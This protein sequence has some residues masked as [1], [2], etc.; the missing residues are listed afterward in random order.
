MPQFPPRNPEFRVAVERYVAAQRYLA[1]LGVVLNRI[2]PGLA[3][4]RLPYRED[5]GQQ[6][7]FFHGGVIGGIAEG[8]M[9]AAAAT[10]VAADAN[11]VG[12][13]YKVNLLS[14]GRGVALLA[15]GA[16][17]RPGRRLIVC[18]ADVVALDED[19]AET[20][21]AIAQG[22]MAVVE[23]PA[24][25]ADENGSKPAAEPPYPIRGRR[26]SEADRTMRKRASTNRSCLQE[27]VGFVLMSRRTSARHLAILSSHDRPSAPVA[28]RRAN[29][30]TA[31][32]AAPAALAGTARRE[33]VRAGRSCRSAQTMFVRT[34]T[35]L[36][37]A[38][39]YGHT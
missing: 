30:P 32:C 19:G 34:G 28:G 2:E 27:F 23:P 22:A 13:E 36:R 38:F 16:V 6:D 4:Y 37:V 8:V 20:L 29:L 39:E 9:G 24:A 7:G 10:L 15:R 35:L 25:T 11:V 1:L 18:R 26:R 3:E 14:P 21:C 5:V 17:V 31:A 33:G 12:A